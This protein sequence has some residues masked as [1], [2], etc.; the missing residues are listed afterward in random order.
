MKK[1]CQINLL[2]CHVFRTNIVLRMTLG[3]MVSQPFSSI[4]II[5]P[6]QLKKATKRP[7]T[8]V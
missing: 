3:K 2:T 1:P 5:G 6:L 8:M 4:K 7:I